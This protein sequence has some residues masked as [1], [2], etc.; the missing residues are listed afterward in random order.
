MSPWPPTEADS[1]TGIDAMEKV[2]N[3]WHHPWQHRIF[4]HQKEACVCQV[5]KMHLYT[6]REPGLSFPPGTKV[7]FTFAVTSLH[8]VL[9]AKELS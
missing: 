3:V 7:S 4:R 6:T 2:N 5:T 9:S 1:M 8:T